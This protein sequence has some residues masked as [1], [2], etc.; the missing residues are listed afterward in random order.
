MILRGFSTSPAF[1][2]ICNGSKDIEDVL[3]LTPVGIA[4]KGIIFC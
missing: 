2:S 1:Y 3:F 4:I